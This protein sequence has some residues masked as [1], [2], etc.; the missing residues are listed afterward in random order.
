M[1]KITSP[2]FKNAKAYWAAS[3]NSVT[4]QIE[5]MDIDREIAEN[6]IKLSNP[7]W[8]IQDGEVFV[9]DTGK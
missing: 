3:V 8:E 5:Y 6:L 1:P 4:N 9:N 2:E 7:P